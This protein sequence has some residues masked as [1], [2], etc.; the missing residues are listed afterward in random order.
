MTSAQEFLTE[1]T[2][3]LIQHVDTRPQIVQEWAAKLEAREAEIGRRFYE[4]FMDE[5]SRIGEGTPHSQGGWV[6]HEL[7]MEAAGKAAGITGASLLRRQ[8]DG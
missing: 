1:F 6:T 3:Q 4:R 7:V 5:L 2:K 8:G